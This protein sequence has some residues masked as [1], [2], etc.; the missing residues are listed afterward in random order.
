M[1]SL[2]NP[3]R[4]VSV[5]I[6]AVYRFSSIGFGKAPTRRYSPSPPRITTY[7]KAAFSECRAEGPGHIPSPNPGH[8]SQRWMYSALLLLLC[9]MKHT[10]SWQPQFVSVPDQTII[11]LMT[12][13]S[14]NQLD[15]HRV[16]WLVGKKVDNI[17]NY[18]IL[19]L[20]LWGRNPL[21]LFY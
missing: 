11:A 10:K 15:Y 13:T 14:I 5:L 8:S 4:Q 3:W 6:S 12:L 19:L 20:H 2:L 1:G 16:Q 7:A 21:M 18:G 9:T 17:F